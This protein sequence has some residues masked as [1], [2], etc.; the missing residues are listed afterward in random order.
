MFTATDSQA[1]WL[2]CAAY[3]AITIGEIAH[4]NP[5]AVATAVLAACECLPEIVDE[6]EGMECF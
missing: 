5:W 6:F 3:T 2:E 1:S 4:V